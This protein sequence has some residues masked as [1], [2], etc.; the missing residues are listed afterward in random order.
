MLWWL[1]YEQRL[2]QVKEFKVDE[3]YMEV[4]QLQLEEWSGVEE[5]QVIDLY[6]GIK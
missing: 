1:V 5:L 4:G 3:L 2:I 6:S